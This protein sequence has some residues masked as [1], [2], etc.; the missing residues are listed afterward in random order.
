MNK[1]EMYNYYTNKWTEIA[2]MAKN[3]CT[4]SAFIYGAHI[5]VFGGY[6]AKCKRTKKVRVIRSKDMI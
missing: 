3:R 2:P 5:Y 1:C 6:S 4:S